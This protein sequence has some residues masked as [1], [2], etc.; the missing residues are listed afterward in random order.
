[1]NNLKLAYVVDDDE[2][3]LFLADKML[4]QVEFCES[5]EKFTSAHEALERL[6]Y[7]LQANENVPD[8]ILFDLNMPNMNG[9]EFIEEVDHLSHDHIPAFVYTSSV[10]KE[11]MDKSNTYSAIRGF[12]TKPLNVQK[13]N[14]ILRLMDSEH[15]HDYAV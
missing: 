3:T 6:K 4:K 2:I 7:A 10:Q 11:D 5:L 12:I 1:M 13:I 15:L 8:V 9:W 14:K